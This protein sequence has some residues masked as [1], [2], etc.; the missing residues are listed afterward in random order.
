[1]DASSGVGELSMAPTQAASGG[2]EKAPKEMRETKMRNDKV[3]QNDE[4]VFAS[5]CEDNSAPQYVAVYFQEFDLLSI[6]LWQR[7][8]IGIEGFSPW[9]ARVNG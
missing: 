4:K 3:D 1:M 6:F 2:F 5:T 7:I 9:K 8:E